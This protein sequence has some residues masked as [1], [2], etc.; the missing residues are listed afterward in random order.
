MQ[1]QLSLVKQELQEKQAKLKE[2]EL[3]NMHLE[4]RIDDH[5]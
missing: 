2:E 1:K 5:G 3:R 4:N